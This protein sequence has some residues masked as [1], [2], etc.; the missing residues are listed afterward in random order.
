MTF[1]AA[2][3]RSLLQD[4]SGRGEDFSCGKYTGDDNQSEE[5]KVRWQTFVGA[6]LSVY[7][8]C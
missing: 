3:L 4:G 1:A 5:I 8:Q 6:V 2:H 7:E